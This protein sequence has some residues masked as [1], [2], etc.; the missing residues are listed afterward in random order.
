MDRAAC[1]SLQR[2]LRVYA[3]RASVEQAIQS[4]RFAEFVKVS[5]APWR[6]SSQVGHLTVS[7]WITDAENEFV[8]LVH[9][10]KL[11]K[12]LQP[13]GHIDDDDSSFVDAALREASEETGLEDLELAQDHGNAI[14]DLDVHHI[15]ARA[16]EPA[17]FQYDIRFRFVAQRA[18]LTLNHEEC[19][20]IQWFKR[21][22]IEIDAMIDSS[23]RRM[24][25]FAGNFG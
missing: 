9:H 3:E 13:G 5:A 16:D 25:A 6:R 21:S 18:A 22:E 4:R 19:H 11:N 10:K 12:W 7:A 15:P 20:A 2:E 8:L 24:A 17:H 14:F 1:N 23:V